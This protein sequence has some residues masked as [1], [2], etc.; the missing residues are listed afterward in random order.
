MVALAVS[1]RRPASVTRTH[2]VAGVLR[3]RSSRTRVSHHDAAFGIGTLTRA[4]AI[5]GG[6]S[7]RIHDP[8]PA[9]DLYLDIRQEL[10]SDFAGDLVAL[11]FELAAHAG[12]DVGRFRRVGEASDDVR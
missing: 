9:R 6:Q 8:S 7:C 5:L 3:F 12:I 10:R 4:A 11:G 2:K 1:A